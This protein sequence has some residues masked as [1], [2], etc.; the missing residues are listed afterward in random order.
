[1]HQTP[2]TVDRVYTSDRNFYDRYYFGAHT[3]E[4][5]AYLMVAMGLYPNIGVIDAFATAVIDGKTQYIVR[6]SRELGSDRMNTKVGPIGVE[7]VEPLR[8]TRV[9]TE[10]N[11]HGLVVRHDVRG[12]HGAVPGAALPAPRRQPHA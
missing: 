2:E 11:E 7:I 6:A 9:Y 5:D 10:P 4:G 3:L 1:M 8:K 12:R